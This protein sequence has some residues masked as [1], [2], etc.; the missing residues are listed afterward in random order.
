[1]TKV[2][3]PDYLLEIL[4]ELSE[5]QREV[6]LKKVDRL[7]RFPFLYPVRRKGRF[8]RLRW[9]VAGEWIVYYQVA[10]DTVYIRVLWPAR[11][12]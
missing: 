3:W 10:A 5:K 7:E 4:R 6:I 11:L 8:R 12:P 9:F 1:M 2:V